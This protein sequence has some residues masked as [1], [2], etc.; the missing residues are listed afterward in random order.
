MLELASHGATV[1]QPRAVELGHVYNVPILVASSFKD[2]PG[3]IIG[4][5]S[6]MEQR[7]KVSGIAEDTDVARITLRGV[8]DQPGIAPRLFDPLADAGI[9]GG[10]I[11]Q[12][13]P[14]GG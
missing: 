10:T 12:N 9:S 14:R 4:G 3:T 5:A 6:M 8:P 7:N 11:V 2:V 1:M 13:A